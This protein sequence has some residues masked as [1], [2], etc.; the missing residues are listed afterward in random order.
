LTMR[1]DVRRGALSFA[2]IL[3]VFRARLNIAFVKMVNSVFGPVGG[4]QAKNN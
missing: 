3:R 4:V 1:T 2:S